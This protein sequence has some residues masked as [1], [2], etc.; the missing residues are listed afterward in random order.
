MLLGIKNLK[1]ATIQESFYAKTSR[2]LKTSLILRP[3]TVEK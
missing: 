3:N 1:I 2:G